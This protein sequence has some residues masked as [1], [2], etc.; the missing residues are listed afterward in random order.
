MLGSI[1]GL[2]SSFYLAKLSVSS[3][4]PLGIVSGHYSQ[5]VCMFVYN[6]LHLIVATSC[7]LFCVKLCCVYA[8]M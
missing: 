4:I 5:L 7:F 2:A 1:M 6:F 8:L 3:S